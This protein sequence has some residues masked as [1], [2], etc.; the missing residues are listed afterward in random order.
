MRSAA[1]L[2]TNP[3]SITKR[4]AGRTAKTRRR[5][6]DARRPIRDARRHQHAAVAR[7]GVHR[8]AAPR[9]RPILAQPP[10]GFGGMAL[11]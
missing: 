8:M 11:H 1:L 7:H 5:G 3:R 10:I 6:N 4:P 9:M 2:L